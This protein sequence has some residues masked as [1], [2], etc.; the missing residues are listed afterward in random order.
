MIK[1]IIFLLLLFF[2]LADARVLKCNVVQV[3]NQT[4]AYAKKEFSREEMEKS[5]IEIKYIDNKVK[6]HFATDNKIFT[7]DY[8]R[9]ED[10]CTTYTDK[11]VYLQE[12]KQY[13]NIY[14]LTMKFP[15]GDTVKYIYSCKDKDFLINLINE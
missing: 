10:C 8:L 15:N 5:L 13:K 4:S 9:T 11:R 1:S 14:R 12:L 7:L 2:T 6:I 3:L